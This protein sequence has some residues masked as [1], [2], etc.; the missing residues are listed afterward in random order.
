MCGTYKKKNLNDELTLKY[1]KI[2]VCVF[3]SDV[4]QSRTQFE[5]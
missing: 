3:G 4:T 1:K 2:C 5:K